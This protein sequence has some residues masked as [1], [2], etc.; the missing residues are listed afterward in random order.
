MEGGVRDLAYDAFLAVT[1]RYRGNARKI[2]VRIVGIPSEIVTAHLS[3][4]SK[5]CQCFWQL[6][7]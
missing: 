5:R 4:T 3:N 2:S 1:W 6:A 7:A